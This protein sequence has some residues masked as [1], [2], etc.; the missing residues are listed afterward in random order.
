MGG[1]RDAVALDLGQRGHA[2]DLKAAAVGED[3]LRP[4]DEI[5]QPAEGSDGVRTRP[6]EKM[7]GVRQNQLGPEGF[8]VLVG[9]GL[10]RA[11]ARDGGEGGRFDR[12]VAGRDDSRPGRGGGVGGDGEGRGSCGEPEIDDVAVLDD[13]LFAFEADGALLLGRLERADVEEGP[14]GNDFGPDESP[15]DVGMDRARGL[16]RGRIF[17]GPARRGPRPCRS[18]KRRSSPSGPGRRAK[19]RPGVGS[20]RP[21]S[22]RKTVF[23]PASSISEISLSIFPQKARTADD[24]VPG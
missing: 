21:Y 13:V 1:E 23:S 15:L 14:A 10:D 5:V 6:E 16:E 2:V 22:A 24:G 17:L 20:E 4:G 8:D 18:C 3:G 12:A 19:K 7:V 11:L 9:E